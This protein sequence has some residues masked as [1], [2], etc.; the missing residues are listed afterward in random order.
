[1]S[2]NRTK[3]SRNRCEKIRDE[4]RQSLHESAKEFQQLNDKLSRR[5]ERLAALHRIS[6]AA[7]DSSLD[8]ERV[9]NLV[10]SE[11]VELLKA[12]SAVI[13]HL[14]E[15]DV[16]HCEV[17]LGEC[18]EQIKPMT[19]PLGQG[20]V[21]HVAA[22]AE[23]EIVPDVEKD[24]RYRLVV[25]GVRSEITAPLLTQGRKVIGVMNV[26]SKLPDAFTGEDLELLVMLASHVA[27]VWDNAT[28]YKALRNRNRELSESYAELRKTQAKLIRQGRLAVLGQMAAIVAHEIRNPLTSIRGFAQR[29]SRRFPKGDRGCQYCHIIVEEVDKLDQVTKSITDFARRPTPVPRLT[30]IDQLLDRVL[31]IFKEEANNK[32]LDLIREYDTNLPEAL[33]DAD[34]MQ[35]VFSNIIRN[36][37]QAS[38]SEGK[39]TVRASVHDENLLVAVND[40]GPGIPQDVRQK[41]FEPFFTTKTHGTGLGLALAQKLVEGHGGRVDVESL[42]GNGATFT[43]VLPLDNNRNTNTTSAKSTAEQGDE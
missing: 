37:I 7:N 11:A 2:V 39:V 6:L 41:M 18:V 26:E 40:S 24:P 13:F 31:L 3:K 28:L 15:N 9:L 30:H 22:T 23:A 35:Q 38:P 34:Q 8:P 14:G 1:M 27:R 43:V 42:P 25:K 10:L 32:G 21:G 17:A 33:I 20:I 19:L 36:A 12:D 5:S 4:L 16:L 29:I